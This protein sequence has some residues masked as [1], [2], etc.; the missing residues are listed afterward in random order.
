MRWEAHLYGRACNGPILSFDAYSRWEAIR[1]ANDE[2]IA[3]RIIVCQLVLGDRAHGMRLETVL[4][5]PIQGRYDN[6]E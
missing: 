6:W 3:R 2:Q 1:R 5:A 4:L